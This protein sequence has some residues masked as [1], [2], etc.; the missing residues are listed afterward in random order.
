MPESALSPAMVKATI[1]L[2]IATMRKY[3][4]GLADILRFGETPERAY[5][6]CMGDVEDERKV[7]D[8]DG[9]S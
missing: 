1:S 8:D 9:F 7:A 3:Y 2:S 5:A 6:Y 4:P